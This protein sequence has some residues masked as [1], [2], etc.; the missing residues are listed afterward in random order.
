LSPPAISPLPR[1][2][3]FN[4][5]SR[6]GKAGWQPDHFAGRKSS[7]SRTLLLKKAAQ[8]DAVIVVRKTFPGFYPR[9]LRSAAKILIFDSD[10][11]IFVR[12]NGDPPRTRMKRFQRLVAERRKRCL[13]ILSGA[14]HWLI[15]ERI[16]G[17]IACA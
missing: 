9:L 11:A 3:G 8:A 12:S 6:L 16:V 14:E 13:G 2:I 17:T 1:V 5:C 7:L 10:D 4:Y 15:A